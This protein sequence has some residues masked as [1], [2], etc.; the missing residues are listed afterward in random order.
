MVVYLNIN[1]A[2]CARLKNTALVQ[3]HYFWVLINVS[4]SNTFNL[5]TQILKYGYRML[6]LLTGGIRTGTIPG[7]LLKLSDNLF[8]AAALRHFKPSI[9]KKLGPSDGCAPIRRKGPHC[10][11]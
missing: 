9:E 4:V 10:H 11:C 8:N 3:A 5:R 6:G 1:P 2:K 7:K